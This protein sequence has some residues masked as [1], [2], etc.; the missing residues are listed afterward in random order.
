M[1]HGSHPTAS[2]SVNA[3]IRLSAYRAQ[4]I[5]GPILMV[6]GVVIAIGGCFGDGPIMAALNAG[7][8]QFMAGILFYTLGDRGERIIEL[9]RRIAE[10]ESEKRE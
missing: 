1:S 3:Q 4:R 10:L 6:L 9:K 8:V 5:L 2:S 7:L